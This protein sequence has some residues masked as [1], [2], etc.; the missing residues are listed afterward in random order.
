MTLYPILRTYLKAGVAA[1]VC[2]LLLTL[3]SDAG[4]LQLPVALA[5][6]AASIVM[7][8]E[9]YRLG[10]YSSRLS[11]AFSY[12][13]VGTIGAMLSLVV[14]VLSGLFAGNGMGVGIFIFMMLVALVFA[15]LSAIGQYHFYWGLDEWIVPNGYDYPEGK[16]RWGFYVTIL[17]VIVQIPLRMLSLA[18]MES[19]VATTISVVQLVLLYQYAQAVRRKEQM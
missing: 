8:Y 15:I 7:L 12:Q 6:I 13:L 4:L 16:I 5:S 19:L 2:S 10:K 3:C 11:T 14:G 1:A 17:G 9:V 18:T